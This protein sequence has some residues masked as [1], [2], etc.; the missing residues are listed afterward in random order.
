MEWLL[1]QGYNMICCGTDAHARSRRVVSSPSSDSS[2]TKTVK[3][4]ESPTYPS[5]YAQKSFSVPGPKRRGI[6]VEIGSMPSPLK[7]ESLPI[8]MDSPSA[9][10]TQT[11]GANAEVLALTRSHVL[12]GVA[13]EQIGV[14][15]EWMRKRQVATGEV[16]AKIDDLGDSFFLVVSGELSVSA[17][18]VQSVVLQQGDFYGESAFCALVV[19]GWERRKG[20]QPGIPDYAFRKSVCRATK[21]SEVLE[22]SAR[23]VLDQPSLHPSITSNIMG[24]AADLE[25][26][27]GRPPQNNTSIAGF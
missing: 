26:R 20:L 13:E 8:S 18:N 6:A 17:D 19:W 24:I 21:P 12:N 2:P 16:L 27:W 10:D 9:A 11:R 7:L 1:G 4:D 23:T 3:F 25:R 14:F 15:W 22:I 5:P